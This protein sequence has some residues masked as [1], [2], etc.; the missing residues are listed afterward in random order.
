MRL[1]AC[2]MPA[3]EPTS[4]AL[5]RSFAGVLRCDAWS[6]T[7]Q[8]PFP[9]LH[10]RS[11][12]HPGIA[13]Q[14]IL[15]PPQCSA[16]SQTQSCD[17]AWYKQG[18]YLIRARLGHELAGYP[19]NSRPDGGVQWQL[20]GMPVFPLRSRLQDDSIVVAPVLWGKKTAFRCRHLYPDKGCPFRV[21]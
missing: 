1:V 8:L 15:S 3:M 7:R 13:S 14:V 9:S 6:P 20:V 17:R 12:C 11:N 10:P 4:P 2:G 19:R 21:P 5:F 18:G 16:R